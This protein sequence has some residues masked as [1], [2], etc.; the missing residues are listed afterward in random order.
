MSQEERRSTLVPSVTHPLDLRSKAPALTLLANYRAE[1]AEVGV[2]GR[3]RGGRN[4]AGQWGWVCGDA[5][6]WRESGRWEGPPIT[7]MSHRPH[8]DRAS[9][10]TAVLS[11]EECN[12]N[13]RP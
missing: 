13:K 1:G 2:H 9:D 4:E 7:R 6:G 12:S 11:E 5:P 8:G 3:I 10:I